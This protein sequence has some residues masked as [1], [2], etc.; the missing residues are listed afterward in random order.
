MTGIETRETKLVDKQKRQ[1]KGFITDEQIEESRKTQIFYRPDDY[2]AAV[3]PTISEERAAAAEKA[4]AEAE[5]KAKAARKKPKVKTVR[6]TDGGK[7]KR[8]IAVLV[9]GVL[10]A[11]FI[12][13]Y[14]FMQS[15]SASLP[16]ISP[17]MGRFK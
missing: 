1:Y 17:M 11:V 7:F 15:Q 4:A 12:V 14:F 6:I 8:L 16:E 13:S 3:E 9:I 10:L 5:A 2:P